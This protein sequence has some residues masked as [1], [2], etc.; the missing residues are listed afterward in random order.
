MKKNIVILFALLPLLTFSQKPKQSIDRVEPPHWWAGMKWNTVQVLVHSNDPHFNEQSVSVNYP[1]VSLAKVNK[2]DNPKY[3][4]L[5]LEIDPTAKPGNVTINF[6]KNTITWPLLKRREGN[7][8]T[9][10]QGLSSADLIYLLMP[11]RFS[12]GDPTNDRVAGMRDQ[13]LNRDSIYYRHGGDLQGVINHLDYL[14]SLGVTALWMTPVIENDMPDRTEHGYAMTSH[15]KIDPRFGGSEAYKKLS[16]ELHKRGMKLIQDAVYN[17]AGLYHVDIQ[18]K[19][20]KDWLHEWPT[21]TNTTYKDA[22]IM[23]PYGSKADKKQMLDGWFTKMMPDLNQSNP[24]MANYLIQ[25]AL[26]SVEEFG[27]DAW[28]IDTYIYNDLDFM[29]RCNQALFNEYPSMFMF[30]ETWVTGTANQAFF[31]ENNLNISQKSNLPGETDF[32]TNY[33][34]IFPALDKNSDGFWN[35]YQ[36]LSNDFLYK[37]PSKMVSFL[38]NHDTNRAL[39]QLGE[40]VNKY[41]MAVTW[42]LTTRGIPQLYYGE[43][44]LM[45]G[46]TWPKDGWVRLD[47]AGG[48][49]ADKKN[50]FTQAGLTTEEKEV[51]DYVKKLGNFRKKSSAI[52]SGKMIQFVPQN[53]VY[54]YFRYDSKQVLMIVLNTNTKEMKLD[55]QRFAEMMKGKA[56]ARNAMTGESIENLGEIKLQ[57]LHALILELE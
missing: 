35:M 33:H 6:G 21:Y 7:G 27:V 26:W 4:A 51:Q 25:H 55:T 19:P 28:R 12:N 56:K 30:G 37:D 17:H 45:K 16:D 15:Y 1:G 49:P 20:M 23:D 47:F 57:P 11:D 5:D 32:Q 29:N 34:G 8:T 43:E 46:K 41:K 13:S 18:D 44:I 2:L 39:S 22:A 36:T 48:W 9:F 3:L 14:Q 54:V 24:V 50:A 52:T 38:N 42:L 40:D 31:M 10:A 53:N